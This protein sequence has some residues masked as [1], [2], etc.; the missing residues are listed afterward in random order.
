MLFAQGFLV[1]GGMVN[2]EAQV[3]SIVHIYRHCR[4]HID[5]IIPADVPVTK[6]LGICRYDVDLDL[7][8]C[9]NY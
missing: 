9:Y 4:Y 2:V 1:M 7:I 8:S 6:A 5:S 3:M